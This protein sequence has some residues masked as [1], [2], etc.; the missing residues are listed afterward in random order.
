MLDMKFNQPVL[1]QNANHTLFMQIH[2]YRNLHERSIITD[3][4]CMEIVSKSFF[5]TPKNVILRKNCFLN[6][7]QVFCL[8]T[9]TSDKDLGLLKTRA[10][11]D[12]FVLH[13]N[14]SNCLTD[15]TIK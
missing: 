11:K 5:H 14:H 6:G 12:L 8:K 15:L 10:N 1:T 3:F 2:K 9:K 7:R 13:G 4:S